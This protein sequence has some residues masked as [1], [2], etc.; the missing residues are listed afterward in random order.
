[1][2]TLCEQEGLKLLV[3]PG[4]YCQLVRN[5][6]FILCVLLVLNFSF[7]WINWILA[8]IIFNLFV[9]HHWHCNAGSVSQGGWIKPP[10]HCSP[11]PAVFFASHKV[12]SGKTTYL[13]WADIELDLYNL[14]W[15]WFSWRMIWWG[16]SRNMNSIRPDKTPYWSKWKHHGWILS[17]KNWSDFMAWKRNE[18]NL[19]RWIKAMIPFYIFGPLM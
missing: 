15:S 1:M 14:D 11:H 8:Q 10:V 4:T 19:K 16:G 9:C 2:Y 18:E 13:S 3:L 7:C 12:K 6:N 17:D 5:L